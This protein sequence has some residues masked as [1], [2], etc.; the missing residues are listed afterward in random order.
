MGLCKNCIEQAQV[1]N[2][3]SGELLSKKELS[4]NH[5]KLKTKCDRCNKK[6]REVRNE[7]E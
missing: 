4:K 1:R 5:I 3:D 6:E 7:C 2:V